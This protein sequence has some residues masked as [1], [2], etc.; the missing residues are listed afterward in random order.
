[1][2]T[3]TKNSVETDINSTPQ[4][5]SLTK[6]KTK[7]LVKAQ[8]YPLAETSVKVLSH[9]AHLRESATSSLPAILTGLAVLTVFFSGVALWMIYVPLKNVVMAP[10][11]VVFKNKRQPVQHLEGGIVKSILVRD[12]DMV[13]EGQPLIELE[14]K[15]ILPVVNM[16]QEQNLAEMAQM[17]RVEAESKDLQSIHFPQ[18]LTSRSKDSSIGRIIQSE[19]RLF[20]ARRDAAQHQI[21]LLKLQISQLKESS[22]GSQERLATKNQEIAYIK[23]QLA[24]NQSLL[25]EG[26]VTKTMV[27]D[28]QRLLLEK[29]G[30]RDLLVASIASE[31][32]RL[33]ELEQRIFAFKAD[34][35]QGAITEMKQSGLRRIDLEERIRPMRDTLERQVIRAPVTGKVVG[36]KVTTVGGV[37][38]ARDS[39][40]EIAP[41]G[42]NLIIEG[43]LKLEDISKVSVGQKA[44][45]VISGFDSRTTPILSAH[46][47]YISD[48][49]LIVN[50]PQGQ[51]AN[52]IAHLELDQESIK[53]LGDLRLMP[54]M[55]AQIT[56]A[57]KPR[58]T[59]DFIFVKM[60]DSFTKAIQ[61]K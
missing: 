47:T 50:S 12:G 33:A 57:T 15:Q 29:T 54:G 4:V 19:E 51:Q 45:A 26:Y 36:L 39:L 38:M 37:V 40:M 22:K 43:K 25:K 23:E 10:G 16:I 6:A 60:R 46:V 44:Q 18:A 3:K 30:E 7:S 61:S 27:T 35:V 11:E 55:T 48:D 31:K 56:I 53:S 49:R 9:N 5:N 42:D 24:G 1:M 58:T 17:A 13:Q 2:N 21:Q 28:Q 14:S 8:K 41:T 20:Y 32:Q 52:Y 59:F 34:R